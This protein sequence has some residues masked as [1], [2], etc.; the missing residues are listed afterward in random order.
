MTT[1]TRTF[2]KSGRDRSWPDPPEALPSP[3]V[4]NHCHLDIALEG[5][6]HPDPRLR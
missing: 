3:V 1:P 4:D 2:P 5:D 6:G